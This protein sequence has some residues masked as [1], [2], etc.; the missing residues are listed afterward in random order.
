MEVR[1]GAR[2]L[3]RGGAR[4][5]SGADLFGR[6]AVEASGGHE[7]CNRLVQSGGLGNRGLADAAVGHR[8]ITPATRLSARVVWIRDARRAEGE[9]DGRRKSA[10]VS[11]FV[12]IS[13]R[14]SDLQ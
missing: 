11:F 3:R 5:T 7:A 13:F 2:K 9:G 1:R 10:S 12:F 8:R 14:T 6:R 4:R